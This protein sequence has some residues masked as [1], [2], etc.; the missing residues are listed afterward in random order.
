MGDM[1]S[2]YKIKKEKDY[3]KYLLDDLEIGHEKTARFYIGA[4]EKNISVFASKFKLRNNL[5]TLVTF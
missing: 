5:Y 2:I 1:E 4:K 3:L